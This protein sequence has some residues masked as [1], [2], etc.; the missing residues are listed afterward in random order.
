MITLIA[1]L[2][3]STYVISLVLMLRSIKRSPEGYEDELGFHEG[4]QL[5]IVIESSNEFLSQQKLAA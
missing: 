5:G 3:A 2:V 1:T 4:R